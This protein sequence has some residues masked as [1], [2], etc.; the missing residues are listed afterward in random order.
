MLLDAGL[1]RATVPAKVVRWYKLPNLSR[2]VILS[3]YFDKDRRLLVAHWAYISQLMQARHNRNS[4][5]W[6][7]FAEF[8]LFHNVI[9]TPL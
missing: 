4:H 5:Q 7:E 2:K 6:I 8:H 9:D 3:I 1:D